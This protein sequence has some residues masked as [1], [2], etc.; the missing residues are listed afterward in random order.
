[1]EPSQRRFYPPL[2]PEQWSVSEAAR[3][4]CSEAGD[5]FLVEVLENEVIRRPRNSDAWADLG[6]ALTRLGFHDRAYLAD[7]TVVQLVPDDPTARYNLGCTL[8]L[9]GRTDEA[10]VLLEEALARGYDDA[11]HMEQDEDLVGLRADPRF[12]GMLRRLRGDRD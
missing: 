5:R 6:H 8:A 9:L 4:A 10:F 11:D 1:M 3:K 12:G 7:A 2:M